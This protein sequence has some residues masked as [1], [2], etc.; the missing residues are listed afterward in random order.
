MRWDHDFCLALE[1]GIYREVL[2]CRID[3][4]TSSSNTEL[5]QVELELMG[6]LAVNYTKL[7]IA[8]Q[9]GLTPWII[10]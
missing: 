1:R 3:L 7:K 4:F 8:N 2:K 10:G 9:L 6:D 5:V